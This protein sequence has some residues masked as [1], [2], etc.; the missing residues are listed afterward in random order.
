MLRRIVERITRGLVFRRALP[1]RYGGQTFYVSSEGGLKFLRYDV[2]QS[3]PILLEGARST[4][5]PGQSIWDI[6][7]NIGLFSFAAS[8]LAGPTGQ[9]YAI[10]PDT[11]LVELLR[12]SAAALG[13]DAAPVEVLPV[14]ISDVLD[15]Q[16]FAVAERARAAS[17]LVGYGLS[18][19]GRTRKL[20]TV[21]SVSLDWLSTKIRPPDVL[22]IDVEG[23]ELRV[24]S[25]GIVTLNQFKPSIIC[26]VSGAYIG[27]VTELLKDCGYQLYDME[28]N[29]C[30][31]NRACWATLAVHRDHPANVAAL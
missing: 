15:L 28:A 1:T 5:E 14:A 11:F 22:K 7:A 24:L 4:I 31:V 26:E 12:K 2:G 16:R 19:S 29:N 27:Q 17:H 20:Q 21:I 9:V 13:H 8:G 18:G 3:D 6:G 30:P 23:A 10:E 25:G